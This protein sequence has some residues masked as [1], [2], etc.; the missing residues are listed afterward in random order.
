MLFPEKAKRTRHEPTITRIHSANTTNFKL[1]K[2]CRPLDGERLGC[3]REHP[4]SRLEDASTSAHHGCLENPNSS[5]KPSNSVP[6]DPIPCCKQRHTASSLAGHQQR[7]IPTRNVHRGHTHDASIPRN[8]V[9]LGAT[10]K[11]TYNT[12][13]FLSH[14]RNAETSGLLLSAFA[15]NLSCISR[16][17]RSALCSTTSCQGQSFES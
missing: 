16:A 3:S 6:S 11:R 5:R 4:R 12:R 13:P 1:R 2:F 17:P 15:L 8:A 10:T 9:R 7:C 14:S